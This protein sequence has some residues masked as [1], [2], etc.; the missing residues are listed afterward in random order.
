[1]SANLFII[2]VADCIYNQPGLQSAHFSDYINCLYRRTQDHII[3]L[4]D[5]NQPARDCNQRRQ[6]HINCNWTGTS[7][8]AIPLYPWRLAVLV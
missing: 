6:D 7:R 1:M 8:Q 5:C 2:A 4:W 3:C